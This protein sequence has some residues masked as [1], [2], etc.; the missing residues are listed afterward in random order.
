M[1]LQFY[2]ELENSELN[3]FFEE[4]TT[5]WDVIPGV[6]YAEKKVDSLDELCSLMRKLEE[7][8]GLPLSFELQIV[9]KHTDDDEEMAIVKIHNA[10]TRV[11]L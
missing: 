9:P 3:K 11:D 10:R 7:I 6:C 8:T 5:I 4:E 2:T 1:L